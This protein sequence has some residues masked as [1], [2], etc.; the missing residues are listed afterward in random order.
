MHADNSTGVASTSAPSPKNSME[1][2]KSVTDEDED[3]DGIVSEPTKRPTGLHVRVSDTHGVHCVC[4]VW[5]MALSAL[6]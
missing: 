3:Y 1:D 2:L 4:F 5:C 6:P